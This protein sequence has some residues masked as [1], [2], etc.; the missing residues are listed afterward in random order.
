MMMEILPQLEDN[1]QLGTIVHSD[2][3]AS[4]STSFCDA[5]SP[6]TQTVLDLC[7]VPWTLYLPFFPRHCVNMATSDPLAPVTHLGRGR[8]YLLTISLYSH[9]RLPISALSSGPAIVYLYEYYVTLATSDLSCGGLRTWTW[10]PVS[11]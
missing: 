6:T 2:V 4:V 8:R 7:T 5:L 11:P 9:G 10:A 3:D 1:R